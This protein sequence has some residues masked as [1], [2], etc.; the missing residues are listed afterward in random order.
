[1]VESGQRLTQRHEQRLSLAPGRLLEGSSKVF[2]E[3]RRCFQLFHFTMGYS[4]K[5]SV[6]RRKFRRGN[7]PRHHLPPLVDIAHI[8]QVRADHRPCFGGHCLGQSVFHI[9]IIQQMHDLLVELRQLF[10]VKPGRRA[11]EAGKIERGNQ[12]LDIGNRFDRIAGS[13]AG[14]QGDNRLRLD[15][16]LAKAAHTERTQTFGK[17]AL[18]PDEQGFMR[19]FRGLRAKRV[20]HLD[21]HRGIGDMVLAAHDM[22]NP[23]LDIVDRRRQHIEPAAVF[24]QD[25][26][27]GQ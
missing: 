1:M 22:G 24:A 23:H 19:K 7:R 17:L 27:V 8:V 6:F 14:Q 12:L 3:V 13:D 16:L 18:G 11:A 26:R 15:I 20:E 10:I 25:D 5:L 4:Q 9:R 2:P 21:L